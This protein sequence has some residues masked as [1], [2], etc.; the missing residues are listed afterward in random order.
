MDRQSF[1]KPDIENT[2]QT[3]KDWYIGLIKIYNFY[4]SKDPSEEM[5]SHVWEEIQQKIYI[6]NIY[7][8]HIG[9][10]N[11]ENPVEKWATTDLQVN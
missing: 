4:S 9:K 10:K 2:N 6:Q 3:T 7:N 11:A 5:K 1:L 8:L